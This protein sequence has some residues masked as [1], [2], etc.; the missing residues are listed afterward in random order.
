MKWKKIV[1]VK[2][3]LHADTDAAADA[4]AAAAAAYAAYATS[5]NSAACI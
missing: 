1:E 5:A 4:G 3:R 2:K